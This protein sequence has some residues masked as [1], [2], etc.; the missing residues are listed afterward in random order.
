MGG[1]SE[2][3]T[4]RRLSGRGRGAAAFHVTPFTR[5]ARAHALSVAGDALIAV[6]LADSIFFSAAT[7]EARGQTALYLLLTMAPF[8]VVAPLIGPAIDRARGG[9]RWM[10]VAFAFSRCVVAAFL[11]NDLDSLL[12]FPEAFALLVMGKGYQV[13]K[14]ALVPLTVSTDAELVEANSKLSLLSGISGAVAGAPAFLLAQV[15][16]P[17]WVVGIAAL[18]YC[19]AGFVALRLPSEPVAPEPADEAERQELRSA[20]ILLAASSMGLLRWVVGF[21]T[22]LLAFWIRTEDKPAWYLG[23]V[24]VTSVAGGLLGAALAPRVRKTTQE[25]DMLTGALILTA[26]VGLLAAWAGGI[27]SAALLAATVAVCAA[28]GKLAFD[29][30]VQRDAPDANRGRSFARFETRFQLIWV[31]G[32]FLP[33]VLPFPV[34]LG[35]LLIAGVA[36]FAAV[37]YTIGRR[38]IARGE[39]PIAKR[40]RLV[41]RLPDGVRLAARPGKEARAERSR[42]RRAARAREQADGAGDGAG[43]GVGDAGPAEGSPTDAAGPPPP[44][45]PPPP[46]ERRWF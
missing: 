14:S 41:D 46:G 9:R 15:G 17:E 2:P 25:E 29:S 20:G 19:L 5:L 28:S 31:V 8:A 39:D 33:V 24:L 44:P 16:G 27:L 37:T 34:Q 21:I 38:S 4:P 6:A 35:Y 23:L 22:F 10:V 7:S 13:A 18:V 40:R 30:I 42:R 12:L 26:V 32:A 3:A 11:V 45:P 36:G 1:V 43:D